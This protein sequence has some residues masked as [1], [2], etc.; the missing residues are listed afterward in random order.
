MSLLPEFVLQT[1]ISR[2]IQ[3]MR[4][5]SRFI[6]QLFRNMSQGNLEQ[7][8]TF[9]K[10][11]TVDLSL[12]YPRTPLAL[13]AI[14]LLLK[15]EN[16]STSGQYLN[17]SMGYQD[18]PDEF[19]YDGGIGEEVLGGSA[20]VG[21]IDE[22]IKSIYGPSRL[23]SATADTITVRANT[24]IFNQFTGQNATVRIVSGTGIGQERNVVKNTDATVT[25]TPN[26][27]V[28]PDSTSIF[29]VIAPTEEILG[30]PSKLYNRRVPEF[31]ERK[32]A[33]YT[34]RYQA[35]V[36]TTRQEQTIYLYAVLK[37]ILFL[38]RTLIEG[39]GLIN[40]RM[41]GSDLSYLPDYAPDNCYMR[42]LNLEFEYPF[43]VFNI[44]SVGIADQF[45]LCLL[46][47]NEQLEVSNTD[48]SVAPQ[49]PGILG[50]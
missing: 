16:E 42:V 23:L 47:G 31:I 35:Q 46:E 17:D 26:F 6:D 9:I 7:M 32:G 28:I 10:S 49:P 19:S 11:Y 25:V 30:E 13:P 48:T 2:G 41:T 15:N 18:P 40:L 27:A 45:Q 4:N 34:N 1:V 12:N 14:V 22:P 36:I 29:D 50:P 38:S 3:T 39:Q 21:A 43:D 5:D 44:E 33:L 8:R 37:A 24:W 20:T